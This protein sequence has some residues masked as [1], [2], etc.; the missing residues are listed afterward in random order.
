MV[1]KTYAL[2][3]LKK[4]KYVVIL[5]EYNGKLL[6]S[7]HK[8]RTTWETQGGHIEIG[9]TTLEAAKRELYEESGA[10]D[11][12]IVPL[13]DYRAW[14]ENTGDGANGVVFRAVITELGEIPESEMAEVQTFETLPKELTYPEI[15][16]T[17]FDYISEQSRCPNLH[18]MRL[19]AEPFEKIK[20]GSKTIEL[21]LNDEKRQSV[22]VGDYIEFSMTGNASQKILTLVT[23]L[24][25]FSTFK[26]L[27]AELPKEKLG[28]SAN[29]VPDQNHMDAFYSKDEQEKY[30]ALGIEL[31]R[32]CT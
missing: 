23:A 20:S 5:S 3:S 12:D 4:Y 30:G 24:H 27:Y 8:K 26:E 9:E 25:R 13:C 29:E 31:R 10:T 17:L 2:G 28:Y 32:Y 11:F 19:K 16:H 15:I 21:R 14:D 22:K 18:K 6:L 1:S 7:R